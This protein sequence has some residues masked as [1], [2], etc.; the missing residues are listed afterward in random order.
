MIMAAG[1]NAGF[2]H[3]QVGRRLRR[4]H[5]FGDFVPGTIG[6]DCHNEP[7]KLHAASTQAC[8]G[9]RQSALWVALQMSARRGNH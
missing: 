6:V 7:V 9:K 3:G 8:G 2:A 5:V 1:A 4:L